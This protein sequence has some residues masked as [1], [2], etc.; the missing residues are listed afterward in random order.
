MIDQAQNKPFC[1]TG[2]NRRCRYT[3]GFY[4]EDCYTFFK[5]DSPTYRSSELLSSI[6]M[7]LHNINT[8]RKNKDEEVLKLKNEIGIGIEH[9]NY[10][11]LISRAEVL[12]RKH[13]CNA[14]SATIA[15][16]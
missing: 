3:N 15:I 16:K 11:D 1:K 6:Q 5:K 14:G 9:E 4:C 2:H 7:V 13:N 8:R 10:E 12:M